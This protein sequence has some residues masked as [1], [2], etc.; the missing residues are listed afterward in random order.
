MLKA[1]HKRFSE[2][3]AAK[4]VSQIAKALAYIHSLNILHRDIKPENI[5]INKDDELKLADFGWSNFNHGQNK[6]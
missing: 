5:L 6:R 3:V 2:I 1:N 4:Y